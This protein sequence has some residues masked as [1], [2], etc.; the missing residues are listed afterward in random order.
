MF[1]Y[2]CT[3]LT[4][5]KGMKKFLLLAVIAIANIGLAMAQRTVAEIKFDK[6]VHDFGTF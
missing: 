2:L 1:Y 5:R 3:V 6:T 4:K